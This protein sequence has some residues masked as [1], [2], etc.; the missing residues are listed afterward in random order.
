MPDLRQSNFIYNSVTN[1]LIANPL[2]NN[3]F[4][5]YQISEFQ[6]LDLEILNNYYYQISKICHPDFYQN[7]SSDQ[8]NLSNTYTQLLN[9]GLTILKD[10]IR[11]AKY[12]LECHSRT[13]KNNTIPNSIINDVFDIQDLLELDTLTQKQNQELDD[14]LNKFEQVRKQ[15]K[16]S[17]ID[18]FNSTLLPVEKLNKLEIAMGEL[19]YIDRII[20]NIKNKFESELRE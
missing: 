7:K 8:Q 14:Y 15:I 13:L 10:P 9:N 3:F 16:M 1:E 20:T 19:A 11:Q 6:L 2:I 12:V 17:I 18:I 4:A 5:M